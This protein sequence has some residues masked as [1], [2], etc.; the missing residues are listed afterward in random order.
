MWAAQNGRFLNPNRA[1]QVFEEISDSGRRVCNYEEWELPEEA[2]AQLIQGE[3]TILFPHDVA[4]RAMRMSAR[5]V[6][7]KE[8]PGHVNPGAPKAGKGR[9]YQFVATISFRLQAV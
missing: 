7:P 9:L 1:A 2:H 5:S 6:W 8:A 4:F 3:A